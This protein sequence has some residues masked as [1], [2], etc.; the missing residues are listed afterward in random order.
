MQFLKQHLY[1]NRNI[2]SIALE[3][4]KYHPTTI[5]SYIIVYYD[6]TISIFKGIGEMVI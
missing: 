4:I 1:K 6:G 3:K 2:K 5:R